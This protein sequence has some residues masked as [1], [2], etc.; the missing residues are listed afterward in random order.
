M[1]ARLPFPVRELH[2]DNGGEA[3]NSLMLGHME[4]TMPWTRVTRSRPYHKN[5]NC[6]VEQK[7]GAIL[8]PYFGDVRL[9]LRKQEGELN[10]TARLLAL[11]T[12]LFVPCRKLVG[13]RPADE[14]A[15]KVS[16]VFDRPKTPLERLRECDPGNP[17]VPRLESVY[18]KTNSIA[19]RRE[20]ARRIDETRKAVAPVSAGASRRHTAPTPSTVSSHL[21]NGGKENRRFGVLSI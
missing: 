8:R 20:I 7:N 19:L 14:K 10:E 18:R 1:T 11:Y 4:K 17:N 16:R 12:N 5:D 2:P 9:D 3:V 6:R 15:V 21:N 13:R